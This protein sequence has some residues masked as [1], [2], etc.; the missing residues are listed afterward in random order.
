MKRYRVRKRKENLFR[1]KPVKRT[2]GEIVVVSVP[3][4]KLVFEVIKGK[5]LMRSIEVF[6]VLAMT[7]LDLTIVSGSIGLDELVPDAQLSQSLLK[8]SGNVSFRVIEP[9]SKLRTIICLNTRNGVGETLHT[10]LDELRR[11][12]GTVFLEG[13]QIAKPGVFIDE[14]ILVE[15]L[16]CGIAH[17]AALGHELDVDLDSLAW[18][19][20]L[21]VRLG[22]VFGIRQFYSH[23]AP[24][25]QEPVE[26]GD[27]SCIPPL[28]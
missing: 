1:G 14:G 6:V 18:I 24:F 9:V 13:L 4:G 10:V 19:G 26:A 8:E 25:L 3:N 17:Q 12:V 2:H 21:F 22:N 20:H 16:V 28:S 7:A 5:K 23:L 27:R 15:L 11:G